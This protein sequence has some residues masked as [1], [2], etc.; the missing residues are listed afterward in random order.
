MTHDFY[1]TLNK[2]ESSENQDLNMLAKRWKGYIDDGTWSIVESEYWTSPYDFPAMKDV[3][4]AL[5]KKLSE[6]K[7]IFFKG[8][9]RLFYNRYIYERKLNSEKILDGFAHK[10]VWIGDNQ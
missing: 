1:W 2:M 4:P 7:L 8:K 10:S 9:K 6:A 3:D 5:Y